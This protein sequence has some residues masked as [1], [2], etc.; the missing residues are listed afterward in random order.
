MNNERETITSLIFTHDGR[1]RCFFDKLIKEKLGLKKVLKFKNCALIKL[2]FD[3]NIDINKKLKIND[4]KFELIYDGD[5]TPKTI[6]I[7]SLDE[8]KFDNELINDGDETTIPM[9]NNISNEEK[10]DNES[11]NETNNELNNQ[12]AGGFFDTISSFFGRKS[13]Q[14]QPQPQ[15]QPQP[16]PQ[17]QT[18]N[19]KLKYFQKGEEPY[20]IE[21]DKDLLLGLLP[22]LTEIN[23]EIISNK[24]F[25][26]YLVRHGEGNHNVMKKQLF[27][28]LRK[29]GAQTFG[30]KSPSTETRLYD[31]KLTLKGQEQATK[32][33]EYLNKYITT[34]I[35]FIGVSDLERTRETALYFLNTLNRDFFNQTSY[36]RI[37]ENGVSLNHFNLFVIP[38]SHELTYTPNKNCDEK[39]LF[40][41]LATENKS[42][43]NFSNINNSKY[44]CKIYNRS[45]LEGLSL[46]WNYFIKFYG[47]STRMDKSGERSRCRN[48]NFINEMLKIIKEELKIQ[49]QIQ[50]QNGGYIVNLK[51]YSKRKPI[52]IIS[53][54]LLSKSK[55]KSKSL[56]TQRKSKKKIKSLTK[57]RKSKTKSKSLHRPKR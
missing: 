33:A 50:Q 16:Q 11:N 40:A 13:T 6:E 55:T 17:I 41:N 49:Q 52:K 9:E 10:L 48:T 7:D 51:K 5:V 23:N 2:E 34:K 47:N 4:A 3:T 27:G 29:I 12:E 35:D 56:T 30:S 28:T 25:I 18:S 26:F 53:Y 32:S 31:S 45:G 43:C 15:A 37:N 36:V 24:H 54:S 22:L 57:Q 20:I 42:L 1:L 21:L 46:N 38:C 44:T 8:E 19:K 14:P 39:Q